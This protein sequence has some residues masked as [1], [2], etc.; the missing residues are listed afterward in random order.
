MNPSLLVPCLLLAAGAQ[1]APDACWKAQSSGVTVDL[2]GVAAVGPAVA[3]ATGAKGTVLRTVD[4]STWTRCVVPPG[5]EALDFRDVHAVDAEQAWILAAG[6][7]ASGRIYATRDGGATWVLQF[8]NPEAAGF[9]DALAFWDAQRGVAMGDPVRGRFQ[10]LLT[11]DG[12]ATWTPAPATGLPPALENEGAFAASGTCLVTGARGWAWFVT[13]GAKASRVFSTRNGGRSWKATETPVPA[14]EATKGLFTAA[15]TSGGRGVV[16]GG[17]YK[18]PALGTL[19]G[20]F[21][22]NSGAT[23]VAAPAQPAGLLSGTT[24]VKGRP[25]A[26]LAVG[27]AGTGRSRDGGQTWQS[28]DGTPLHAVSSAGPDATWAVGP[29]GL[30]LKLEPSVLKP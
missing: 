17:D 18:Q 4:G 24:L 2:R 16:L 23:W 15:F 25:K 13:G 11:Q 10:V 29:K 5:A 21:S 22:T 12:G 3:W 14:G 27:L 7:G 20:A 6:P 28:L 1:S 26:I 30:L 8:T 9:L 19:N